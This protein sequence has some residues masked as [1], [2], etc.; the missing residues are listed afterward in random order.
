MVERR[1]LDNTWIEIS[2]AAYAHNLQFFRKIIGSRPE[3]S[4]VIKANAYGHGWQTIARLAIKHQ[5]DSFCV[6][7][8]NEALKLRHAGFTQNI[9]VMGHVPLNCLEEAV[10]HNLRLVVYNKET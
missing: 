7:S 10:R 9:L 5:V 3:L 1:F 2:E 6:H 8:L 4:V